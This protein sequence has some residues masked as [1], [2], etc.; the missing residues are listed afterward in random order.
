MATIYSNL[1]GCELFDSHFGSR[2]MARLRVKVATDYTASAD[3]F[4]LGGGG[5]L[6]GVSTS[7]DLEDQI[8]AIRRDGKTVNL[9]GGTGGGVGGTTTPALYVDTVAVSSNNLTA[10]IAGPTST[11][12]DLAVADNA[13]PMEVWVVYDLS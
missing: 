13:I 1:V 5:K 6:F 9:I 8:E 2:H 3:T 4:Q 10:E 12:T 11:E 7:L